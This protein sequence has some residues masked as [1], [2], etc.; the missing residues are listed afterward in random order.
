MLCSCA[1]ETYEPHMR[2]FSPHVSRGYADQQNSQPVKTET[3]D[4]PQV[5]LPC[6]T[7][8]TGQTRYEHMQAKP[9]FFLGLGPEESSMRKTRCRTVHWVPGSCPSLGSVSVSQRKHCRIGARTELAGR[10]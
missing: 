3:V 9:Q 1:P 10:T 4:M 7:D 8:A 5:F 6:A 2:A